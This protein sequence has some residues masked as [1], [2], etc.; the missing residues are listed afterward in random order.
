MAEGCFTGVKIHSSKIYHQEH[1]TEPSRLQNA[2][3]AAWGTVIYVSIELPIWRSSNLCPNVLVSR[4]PFKFHRRDCSRVRN[5]EVVEH[6]FMCL[7]FLSVHGKHLKLCMC[8]GIA[9]VRMM[10]HI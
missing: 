9:A 1:A 7:L 8:L 5:R 10:F 3:L 6:S 4:R 2:F